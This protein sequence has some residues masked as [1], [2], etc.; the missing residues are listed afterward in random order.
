V[1]AACAAV[2]SPSIITAA[3]AERLSSAPISDSS[4]TQR[5]RSTSAPLAAPA[6]AAAASGARASSTLNGTS[7]FSSR[8]RAWS[9]AKRRRR[10]AAGVK[11][12]DTNSSLLHFT[13]RLTSRTHP[14]DRPRLSDLGMWRRV[15]S[16][17][18]IRVA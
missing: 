8:N 11:V 16:R 13:P 4:K 3:I 5:A 2:V 18:R 10:G 15:R 12:L 9:L 14:V 1:A 7:G 6:E 17:S